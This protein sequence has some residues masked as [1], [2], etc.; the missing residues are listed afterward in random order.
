ML[1]PRRAGARAAAAA[2]AVAFPPPPRTRRRAPPRCAAAPVDPPPLS[3]P[4]VRASPPAKRRAAPVPLPPIPPRAPRAQRPPPARGPQGRA[5]EHLLAGGFDEALLAATPVSSLNWALETL[6]NL[7]HPEVAVELFHW[8]RVTRRAT[9]HSLAKLCDACAAARAPELALRAVRTTIRAP[10]P[11]GFLPAPRA[12][13]ALLKAFRAAGDLAGARAALDEL[14]ARGARVNVYAFNI[15]LRICADAGDADAAAEVLAELRAHGG[16]A[17]AG[18]ADGDAEEGA[19][20]AAD[21]ARPPRLE[22]AAP[23][24]ALGAAPALAP[25]PPRPPG[26][27]RAN[28]DARSYSA[29]LAAVAAAGKWPRAA[30]LHKSMREDGVRADAKLGAQLLGCL[31]RAARPEAAEAVMDAL[32]DGVPRVGGGFGVCG[33]GVC[34]VAGGCFGFVV[35]FGAWRAF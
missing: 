33:L 17:A 1:A 27:G 28:A 21:G 16:L 30:A 12:A 25:R 3:A 18:D 2:A 14:Q 23:G 22:T 9:Q 13:A 19:E 35:C 15:L 11:G 24:A 10:A 32:A 26:R 6:G 31:A 4:P 5:V 20:G 34:W 8:M 29:A 7:G